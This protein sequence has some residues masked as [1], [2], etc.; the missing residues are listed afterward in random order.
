M[1]QENNIIVITGACGHIGS[2]LLEL[3]DDEMYDIIAV[4][5][6]LT[7]RYCSLFNLKSK[8]RFYE[9]NFLDFLNIVFLT[10]HY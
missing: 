9:K 4:D 10:I 5:N 7:Q 2:S 6:M 1:T 8:I 3:L